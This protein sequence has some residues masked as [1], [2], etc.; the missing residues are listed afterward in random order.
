VTTTAFEILR[1]GF[2]RG[3]FR[4]VLFDFD[5]TLSLLRDDWPQVMVPLMVEVLRGTGTEES[6]ADLTAAVEEAIMRRNGRPTADQMAHLA[7]EVRRRG[8]DPAAPAVYQER[9][10]RLLM[11][12]VR[13]RVK[14]LEEGTASPATWAVPGSHALL[15][16]LQERGL[17]LVLASGTELE[18]V[19][20]EGGL[21][22]LTGFFGHQV[23]APES[24]ESRF[25]KAAVVEQLLRQERLLGEEVLGIGDGP[26][27]IEAVRRVGGVTVGVAW[28]GENPG[29]IE[30]GK[31]RR[32][33]EAGADLVVPDYR[34][35]E[36]LLRWLF[37]E[38]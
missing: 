28:D 30:A 13:P 26:T 14:A 2:R 6:E 38:E 34:R 31:R 27:E 25:S 17:L 8:Q 9:F 10:H 23:Y 36:V 18:F 32:L 21:L 11:E 15:K 12:R 7:E 3:R 4:A 22:G 37:A 19:H 16:A 24:G 1:S 20:R 35:S 5:G 33:A 29:R